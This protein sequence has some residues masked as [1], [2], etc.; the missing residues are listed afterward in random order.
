MQEVKGLNPGAA[1]PKSLEPK[2]PHTLPPGRKD[3][4]RSLKGMVFAK[5]KHPGFKK[6]HFFPKICLKIQITCVTL[7]F[8]YMTSESTKEAQFW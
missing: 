6:T 7:Y 3:V 1:P 5:A 8:S 2:H 4:S